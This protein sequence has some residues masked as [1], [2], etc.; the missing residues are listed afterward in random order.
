M[1]EDELPHCAGPLLKTDA[2]REEGAAI[3]VRSLCPAPVQL[4]AGVVAEQSPC[5]GCGR[6]WQGLRSPAPA[7]M[8]LCAE[9]RGRHVSPGWRRCQQCPGRTPEPSAVLPAVSGRSDP[10]P[11]R[12]T[13]GCFRSQGMC[14]R[15]T[16][17]VYGCPAP[18]YQLS[19]L[20]HWILSQGLI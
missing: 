16:Q 9:D 3:Q 12:H 10:G 2:G 7:V 4:C 11:K 19:P 8:P 13:S 6:T 14:L 18:S 1:S 5:P 20:C 17:V 15:W